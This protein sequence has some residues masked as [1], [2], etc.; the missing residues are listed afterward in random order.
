LRILVG[1][2]RCDPPGFEAESV[3]VLDAAIDDMNP[4]LFGFLMERLFADG[5][6]DVCWMPAQMKKNRPGTRVEVICRPE[7][8]ERLTATLLTESTS[9]GVRYQVAA[10]RVLPRRSV[11]VVTEYGPVDA[12]EIRMPDG[13]RRVTPEYDAC[14]RIAL[15]KGVAIWR[16]YEAAVAAGR[17]STNALPEGPDPE[18]V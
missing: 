9:T 12:K 2:H 5:A 15:L 8:V 18:S 4:E 1:L 17:Q 14:R 11:L 10:R 13:S 16:V 6:L 3:A 7:D